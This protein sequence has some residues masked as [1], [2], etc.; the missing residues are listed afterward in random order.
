MPVL[1]GKS[2]PS[3]DVWIEIISA[4]GH[5]RRCSSH[6]PHGMCG[7]KLRFALFISFSPGSHIPHGMCGLKFRYYSV[8][9]QQDWSHPSRDVWIEI[10]PNPLWVDVDRG[11][12]PH[13]MCGL[14]S[15]ISHNIRHPDQS[16]PSRDVWIEIQSRFPDS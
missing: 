14:K 2:H 5:R 4:F 1:S 13:G 12:I 15:R 10:A 8:F 16:H 7:L 6:I 9:D 3:R 11:H